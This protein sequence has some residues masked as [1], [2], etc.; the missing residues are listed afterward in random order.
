VILILDCASTPH[1]NKID[2]RAG[3]PTKVPHQ[4]RFKR[5]PDRKVD[6]P[7]G[8]FTEFRI[9]PP[10]AGVSLIMSG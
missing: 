6:T 2:Q 3:S 10:R 1:V 5:I 8:E 4:H 9:V 7:P